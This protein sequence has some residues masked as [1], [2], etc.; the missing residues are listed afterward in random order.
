MHSEHLPF[1]ERCLELAKDGLGLVQSNPLV[2]A[3]IVQNQ[4]ILAEGHHAY[5]GG[6]HAE[7]A[8]LSNAS[9]P[10]DNAILYCNLE[11]C[12][13]RDKKTPPC[14]EAII[15]SGIKH[16]VFCNLDPNPKVKGKGAERLRNAGIK[17]EYGF[18]ERKARYLNRHF[19]HQ[20]DSE[21]PYLTIKLATSLD[22]KMALMNGK[23]KWITS[24]NS[25]A[26]VQ[27]IRLEH[28]GIL[29]GM[30]TILAD[31]PQLTVRDLPV[32]DHDQFNQPKVIVFHQDQAPELKGK[33]LMANRGQEDVL[34]LPYSDTQPGLTKQGLKTLKKNGIHSLLIEGGPK[35][36]SH[37]L[38]L[39]LW[40]EYYQFIAPKILGKGLG[41]DNPE[42]KQ[43]EDVLSFNKG[44]WTSFGEDLLFNC[45]RKQ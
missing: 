10:L 40:D 43:L 14:T 37:F 21:L 33:K 12:C 2:G 4:R 6:P 3:V 26:K 27:L 9:G 30:G 5:F 29:T 7:I 18:L 13:H 23:S 8:A 39:D 35:T 15:A 41:I 16:V 22:G 45:L 38:K 25:R 31:N 42:F 1:L 20:F 11:P 17:V 34:F 28:Q 36:I 24:T 32:L 44:R 19:Y